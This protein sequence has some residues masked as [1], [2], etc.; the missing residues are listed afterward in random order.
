MMRFGRTDA[1]EQIVT[2]I[3]EVLLAHGIEGLR[4]DDMEY[5]P[6]LYLS[7]A[8]YMHGCGFGIAVFERIETEE[9]NPNVALEVGYMQALKKDVCLLKDRT[10]KSLH[11][12]LFGMLF[13]ELDTQHVKESVERGLTGWL[14]DKGYIDR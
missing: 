3:K 4:A 11:A 2:A 6:Q 13:R 14:R 7:L 10:L 12:D 1:H 8:T 5:H 9:F